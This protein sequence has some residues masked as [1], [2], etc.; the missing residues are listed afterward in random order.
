M[1]RKYNTS[2]GSKIFDCINCL[3]MIIIVIIMIY[4]LLH[5]IA[6]SFSEPR[7]IELGTVSFFPKGINTAGYMYILSDI[8]IWRA[9]LM[10]ITYAVLKTLFVLLFT[11]CV[12]YSLSTEGFIFKKPLTILITITMFFKGGLIPTYTIISSLG[13][14]DTIWVMTL[15]TCISAFYVIVFRTFFKQLPYSLREAAHIDGASDIK[16]LFGI[17]LPLSKP[18]LSTIALFTIVEV[19]N[20]WFEALIYLQQQ[21]RNPLQMILRR[22]VILDD[23]F[24]MG[25]AKDAQN[26]MNNFKIHPQNIQMAAVVVAMVPVYIVYPFIQK[27]FTKGIMIGSLKG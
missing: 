24:Q 17:I 13:L 26:L 10:T 8:S 3:F 2:V 5:V 16:I 1:N 12:A 27:Y 9:Y 15:P 21:W 19:W 6:V 23:L 18:I 4:P 22:I 20:S 14:L 7:F 11:S 25:T